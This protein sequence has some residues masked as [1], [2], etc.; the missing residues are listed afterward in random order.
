MTKELISN[1]LEHAAIR[2]YDLPVLGPKDLQVRAQ[3]GAMK[4]GTE[5]ASLGG[6]AAARL[7]RTLI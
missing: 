2:S 1:S 7:I 4:H 6:Y 5:M 3:F